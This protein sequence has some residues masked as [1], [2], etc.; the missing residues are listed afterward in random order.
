MIKINK[1]AQDTLEENINLIYECS[2]N[3]GHWVSCLESIASCINARSGMVGAD[4]L[5]ANAH[6][7]RLQYGYDT[8]LVQRLTTSLKDQDVWTKALI[9]ARP[10]GFVTDVMLSPKDGP[11]WSGEFITVMSEYDVHHTAGAYADFIDQMGIRI[12]FQR[13]QN[14]GAYSRLET[15]YLDALLPHIKHSLKLSNLITK[16]SVF[17]DIST[18]A[19]ELHSDPLFLITPKGKVVFANGD[20]LH[21]ISRSHNLKLTS[22]S[23][24]IKGI[25]PRDLQSS[26]ASVCR[27]DQMVDINCA[28]DFLVECDSNLPCVISISRFQLNESTELMVN[29]SHGRVL[30]LLKVKKADVNDTKL[31]RLS[32]LYGLS[33]QELAVSKCLADGLSPKEISEFRNRSIETIRTQ[34]KHITAKVTAKSTNDLVHKLNKLLK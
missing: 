34:I 4:D 18:A 11:S 20:A 22:G 7:A 13:S 33:N 15:E 10:K 26:I 9:E 25:K 17:T 29:A 3:P 30:A 28:H 6:L 16:N 2:L 14:Q 24:S 21:L 32:L 23:L 31:S 8:E 27:T 19:L 5:I 1:L 12:A